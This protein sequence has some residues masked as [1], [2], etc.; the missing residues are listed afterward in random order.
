M[1]APAFTISDCLKA[2]DACFHRARGIGAV[3]TEQAVATAYQIAL[4]R[5]PSR[6][7]RTAALTFLERQRQSYSNDSSKADEL[8]LAD[9]CRALMCV[10]EFVY[11]D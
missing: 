2:V 10:N 11:V 6:D 9:F 8:A 5:K 1:A 7:E 3:S 4:A